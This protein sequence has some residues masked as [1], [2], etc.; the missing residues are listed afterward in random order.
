MILIKLMILWTFSL[1]SFSFIHLGL[2]SPRYYI[3][4]S[5]QKAFI[6]PN[7]LFNTVIKRQSP[8]ITSQTQPRIISHSQKSKCALWADGRL[9]HPVIQETQ[10]YWGNLIAQWDHV[11]HWFLGCF[12]KGKSSCGV[13]SWV[14]ILWLIASLYSIGQ[15]MK[16]SNYR[17]V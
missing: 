12:S 9:P 8:N 17:R 14:F 4:L 15:V 16:P 2:F 10:V 3:K 13:T 7:G 6:S 5:L 1:Q 11:Q